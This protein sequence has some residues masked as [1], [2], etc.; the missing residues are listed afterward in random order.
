MKGFEPILESVFGPEGFFPE[1]SLQTLFDNID[2]N[3]LTKVREFAEA[4]LENLVLPT[5][6]PEKAN[7]VPQKD[8][9][10]KKTKRQAI[11]PQEVRMCA[12]LLILTI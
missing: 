12:Q 6:A 5:A 8:K 2:E 11:D 1:I 7:T 3:I 9:Y 4:Q 10:A